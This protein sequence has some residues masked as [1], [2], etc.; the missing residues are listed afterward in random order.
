MHNKTSKV[1]NEQTTDFQIDI[2]NIIET[3][4]TK[5]I[6]VEI[7]DKIQNETEFL[8]ILIVCKKITTPFL[9][10]NCININ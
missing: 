2:W 5:V 4:R 3:K 1:K 8:S 7:M 6:A 9:F 10:Q